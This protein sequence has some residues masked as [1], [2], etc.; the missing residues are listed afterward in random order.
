MKIVFLSNYYTHH[1]KPICNELFE[2]TEHSFYFVSTESFSEERRLLGWK[3]DTDV[4]F[5]QQY[6]NQTSNE[7]TEEINNCDAL[8]F[9]SAPRFLIENRLKEKKLVFMYSERIYKTGYNYMKWLPRLFTFWKNYGRYGS[10]YLLCASAYTAADY[11]M[12]NTFIN[13]SYKWGYFPETK[14]YDDINSL[15]SEKNHKRIIWCG[16]FIEYKHPEMAVA[17][18]ER[19]KTEGC[20]FELDLIGAGEK[21]AQLKKL[22]AEKDLSDNV[23]ILGSMSPQQVRKNMEDAGIFLFTS[24]F[25][26]GWGAVLNEAMNSGCAVAASHAIGAVPYLLKHREN[27]LI[28]EYGN[29]EDLCSKVQYLLNN[30][31]EQ[32]RLGNNAYHTITDLWN[33]EIAGKRLIKLTDEIKKHGCC[34]LFKEGPCSKAEIIRN[35]WFKE[36]E[37][38]D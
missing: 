5:L 26:E 7:I 29:F 9:G 12:H 11:A 37:K 6:N 31:K 27:G 1:Q 10:F 4:V 17:V 32:L 30:P 35:N 13:K 20:E 24:D 38:F 22:I 19:L 25:E 33:A 28:Y 14:V 16:R 34:D 15:L 3:E 21:E 18:A 8:L 36:N 23:K 2:L